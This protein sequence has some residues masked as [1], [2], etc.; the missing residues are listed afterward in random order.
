MKK[1]F[2]FITMLLLLAGCAPSQ[3]AVQGS[4]TAPQAALP[5]A[6]TPTASAMPTTASSPT[7]TSNP[8]SD[9]GWADI[10]TLLA[11]FDTQTGSGTFQGVI[12]SE[13]IKTL[14]GI[15]DNIA[16]VPVDAC[17]EHARGLVLSSLENR[18]NATQI[19]YT[20]KSD[21]PVDLL[22]SFM[23]TNQMMEAAQAEL[24]ALGLQV[25]LPNTQPA[26]SNSIPTPTQSSGLPDLEIINDLCYA[27]ATEGGSVFQITGEV[28][29]NSKVPMY[30]LITAVVYNDKHEVVDT[31]AVSPEVEVLAPGGKSPFVTDNDLGNWPGATTCEEQAQG[32]QMDLPRQDLKI[33]SQEGNSDAA[34]LHIQG[35]VENTGTTPAVNVRVVVTL[36]DVNGKVIAVTS[37]PSTLETIPAGGTSPFAFYPLRWSR[38]DHYE[39]LVRGE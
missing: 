34:G 17:T 1:Y 8:C 5:A 23:Q 28:R 31:Q 13:L 16:S 30:T 4:P 2:L 38:Y 22:N 35:V 10:N 20:G 9:L 15:K 12:V 26:S 19:M 25:T 36:Y 39:L 27:Y 14:T 18:I 6:S 7:A 11:E 32:F 37:T 21:N 3:V 33:L 24:T 29:N